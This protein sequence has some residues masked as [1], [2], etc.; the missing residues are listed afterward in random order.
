MT[1][2]FTSEEDP[3]TK[4]AINFTFASEEFREVEDFA[5]AQALFKSAANSEM[6]KV[7][8]SSKEKN[9]SIKYQVLSGQTA[10]IGVIKQKDKATGD[11]K[12]FEQKLQK[13]ERPVSPPIQTH[14]YNQGH[15]NNY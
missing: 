12:T 4:Q 13:V 8:G 7:K 10:M 5:L 3:V 15:M 11:M 9:M 1:F 14:S 6:R 2:S